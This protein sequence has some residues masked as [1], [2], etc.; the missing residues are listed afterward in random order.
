MSYTNKKC[1]YRN[2]NFIHNLNIST[3]QTKH[4]EEHVIH[5]IK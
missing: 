5:N 3:Q 1:R 2:L 4:K